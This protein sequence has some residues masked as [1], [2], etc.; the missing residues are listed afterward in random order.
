MPSNTYPAVKED[1]QAYFDEGKTW[2]ALEFSSPLEGTEAIALIQQVTMGE[3][4]AEEAAAA[5]DQN[6]ESSA[7]Q[8]G[9]EWE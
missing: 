6:L 1:M 7:I 5:Y 4:T 2:P 3:I 9:L 8:L